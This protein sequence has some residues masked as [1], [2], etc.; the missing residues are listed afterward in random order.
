MRSSIPLVAIAATATHAASLA[1]VCTSEYVQASLPSDDFY[2]GIT[3][4]TSSVSA[5]AVYN[6]SASSTAFFPAAVIDYCDVEFAYTHNGR[7]DQVL[8]RYWLPA[9]SAFENRFLTTGG[10]A[11]AIN[12]GT[13]NLP[14]GVQYGAAAGITDGG[15]G[16][17]DTEFDAVFLLANGTVDWQAVYMFGYQAL[18]EMTLLG[19]E[20]T[21]NFFNATDKVYGYYQSCSEGGREGWSQVQRFADQFDGAAIGAPAFR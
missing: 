15:F 18:H 10:F 6:Y 2:Q 20:L 8:V 21:S 9:P 4:D 14:G 17:F 7:G 12:Q 13:Q 5:S 11:F 19:K 1:S 16:S 3:I